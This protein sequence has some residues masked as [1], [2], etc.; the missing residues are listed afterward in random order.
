MGSI[1]QN[2]MENGGNAMSELM[3]GTSDTI[4]ARIGYGTCGSVWA[5]L[6]N[7]DD[8]A[9]GI[10][11]K[12]TDSVP[13]CPGSLKNEVQIH[14]RITSKVPGHREPPDSPGFLVN[15]PHNIAFLEPNAPAWDGIIP[16]LPQGFET[17]Q[18]LINER[19][20]PLDRPSRR[21]L[22]TNYIAPAKSDSEAI[23]YVTDSNANAHC[24]VRPYLGRRQAGMAHSFSSFYPVSLRNIP[25]YVD[26]MLALGLPLKEY[27]S[28]V[29]DA[30]AFMYWE[31]KIDAADVEYVL[32]RSRP[33]GT[34]NGMSSPSLLP[35]QNSQDQKLTS[36]APQTAIHLGSRPFTHSIFGDHAL[37]IL[38]FD[39]CQPISMDMIG[40]RAAADKFWRN[41]PYYPTPDYRND[42]DKAIWIAFRERFLVTSKEILKD[43]DDEIRKLPMQLM[44]QVLENVG[45]YNNKGSRPRKSSCR[46]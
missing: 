9:A 31:V 34:D 19:I 43:E 45:N 44:V 41:D 4:L 42:D 37:W 13:D 7:V 28:A 22:I 15:I 3:V 25:L 46:H 39:N 21:L 29:A 8:V 10:V 40:V 11:L 35:A 24:L 5:D 1:E 2:P 16:R 27:A 33:A 26:Q 30:L 23:D 32:G 20:M 14:K 17:C 12:R 18:A 36:H 6:A 38:D